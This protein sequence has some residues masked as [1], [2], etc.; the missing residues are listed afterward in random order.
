[1]TRFLAVLSGLLLTLAVGIMLPWAAIP[2]LALVV[3]GW[4]YRLGAVGAVLLALA[5]LAW[6][7]TGAVEAAATGLVATTYLLNTATVSA[8]HGVVPTT[9]PSVAGAVTFAGAAVL[10][11]LV[12]AHLAWVPLAAPILV[13]LLYAAVV[14]GLALTRTEPDAAPER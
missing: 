1:M 8:P 9:V 12:P 4:R 7:D 3:A 5:T 14:R 13:V 10:A 6:S 11:A 2:A